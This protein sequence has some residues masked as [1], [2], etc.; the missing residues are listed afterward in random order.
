R[1]LQL[2]SPS[3]DASV[4]EM[5][6]ALGSGAA[7][8]FG[9]ED[10]LMPGPALLR[11]LRERRIT[12]T[13]IPPSALAVMAPADLPDLDTLVVAG[14]ACPPELPRLWGRDRRFLNAYGP[15]E[16]TVCATITPALDP[17]AVGPPPIGRPIPGVRVYV[18][19]ANGGM[20]PTGGVGELWIGGAGVARGYRGRPKLT[21]ERFAE[22]PFRPG[23]R[24]YRS[25]DM[26]RWHPDGQLRFLGRRDE[27][28]KLRGYRIELGEV[29]SALAELPGV[30]AA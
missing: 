3:F 24:V 14:E 5:A 22:D 29:E 8:H 27:Q 15:T 12:V 20:A 25:G 26:V 16:A 2:S 4:A 23:E 21:A 7:L 13:T 17:E 19:D 10:D 6:V 9:G 18:V 30:M 28:V 1:V 11:L